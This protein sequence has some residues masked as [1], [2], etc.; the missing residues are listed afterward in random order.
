MSQY[1]VNEHNYNGD[2]KIDIRKTFVE[3]FEIE[4]PNLAGIGD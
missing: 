3:T 4:D 1:G 2:S